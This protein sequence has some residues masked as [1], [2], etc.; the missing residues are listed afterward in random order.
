M[1]NWNRLWY[2]NR[3]VLWPLVPLSL[4]YKTFVRFRKKY[5][6]NHINISIPVI[7]VGNITVGG[8][9][10]TPLVIHIAEYLI[11]QGWQPGIISRGYKGTH[12]KSTLVD[13]KSDPKL[14]GDEAVLL[15]KRLGCPMVVGKNRNAALLHL[16]NT[17]QAVD[18]VIS[19]DGLQHYGLA[20]N[21]EIAVVDAEREFGNGY[22]L[23]AGPL[24]EP[25]DR[26]DFVDLIVRNI[27]LF[28][29]GLEK[30]PDQ[31]T[32]KMGYLPGRL[33]NAFQKDSAQLLSALSGQTVHAIAGIGNPERFFQ[34]LASFGLSVI[35]H[36]FPD[37]HRFSHR[38]IYFS[39]AFP[40]IM[41]EKDAVKCLQFVDLRHWV[42]PIQAA[43]SPMFDAKLL[44]L[45]EG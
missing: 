33:Y 11:E 5:F 30:S 44:T 17:H 45:L 38:D 27:G 28:Y 31:K 7:V 4:L 37:H 42:L 29:D 24:R 10:K 23:P 36:A 34:L 41:T 25:I 43:I 16:L 18:V 12:K 6:K 39:D 40:V 14:V 8:T 20:R 26:L 3:V 22:C 13:S 19:D 2:Q 21:I 32:Y 15:A 1:L 35:K 9:G